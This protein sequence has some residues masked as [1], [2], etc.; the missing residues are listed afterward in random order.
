[1]REAERPSI[2]ERAFDLARTGDFT[3]LA[4]IREW[5]RH[6]GYELSLDQLAAKAVQFQLR[7]AMKDA[8]A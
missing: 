4:Q 8:A 3:N 6:E 7:S 5:L 1:M 2:L